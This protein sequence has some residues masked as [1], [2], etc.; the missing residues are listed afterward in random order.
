MVKKFTSR[1]IPGYDISGILHNGKFLNTV[2]SSH[3]SYSDLEWFFNIRTMIKFSPGVHFTNPHGTSFAEEAI[4]ALENPTLSPE[5]VANTI[6]SLCREVVKATPPSEEANG[7]DDTP[8]LEGFLW[9]IWNAVVTIAEEDTSSH[10]RLAAI[11]PA[12]KAKSKSGCEGWRI[13]GNDFD[14]ANLPVYGPA[15][16]ESMNGKRSLL[17]RLPVWRHTGLKHLVSWS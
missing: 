4:A 7:G 2:K 13:W 6:T 12:I 5:E 17:H 14:W 15:V 1:F 9:D 10:D 3:R 16:R 11:L 8:G